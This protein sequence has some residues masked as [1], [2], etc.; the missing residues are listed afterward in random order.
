MFMLEWVNVYAGVGLCLC[1]SG[2]MLRLE[3]VN[4][5]AGVD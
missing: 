4:V 5:Y 3:W 1:W 2:F